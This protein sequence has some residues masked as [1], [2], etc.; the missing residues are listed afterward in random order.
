MGG[1]A[2]RF[3]HAEDVRGDAVVQYAFVVN[4]GVLG[5]VAGGGVVVVVDDDGIGVIGGVNGFGFAGV[6]Q[7]LFCAHARL[8]LTEGLDGA[9]KDVLRAEIGVVA[10][11]AVKM[12]FAVA[13]F[14]E[15]APARAEQTFN[16]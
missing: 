5:A 1:D 7:F 11:A 15:D 14:A 2:R 12:A 3:E 8:L 6:K 16:G 4:D 10:F 9:G 13:H